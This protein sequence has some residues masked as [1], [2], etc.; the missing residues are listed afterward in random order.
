MS[1][2]GG[3]KCP[4][5]VRRSL[6]VPFLITVSMSGVAFAQEMGPLVLADS[7]FPASTARPLLDPVR[8]G[9]LAPMAV[10]RPAGEAAGDEVAA[11]LAWNATGREPLKNGFSRRLPL[12]LA[13]RLD[14]DLPDAPDVVRAHAG[15]LVTTDGRW[16]AWSG[17]VRVEAA[18][19]LRLHLR[20]GELPAGARLWV[21]GSDGDTVGPFG[22]ELVTD[23]ELWTPSVTGPE[24]RLQVELDR[25]GPGGGGAAFV[26][27]RV[28]ELLPLD[29]ARQALAA[30]ES[31]APQTPVAGTPGPVAA[32]APLVLSCLTDASC[33]T[34]Q[35]LDV[36]APYRKAV[37]FL[38]Y[39]R[40]GDGYV[41]TGGLLNSTA[42]GTPFLLTANHCI[43][44]Q[45]VAST[46]EAFWD[47]TTPTCDGA[48]P[49]L[50][51][52]PRS[53][54]GT[55]LATSKQSD[56]TLLRLL[57]IPD[58]RVFLGW[59]AN[60][61]VVA[62][63]T[64]LYRISHPFPDGVPEPL[65]QRY[66]ETVVS[67][68]DKCPPTDGDG[69]PVGGDGFLKSDPSVGGTFPGSSGA[70]VIIAGGQVVGQLFGSC[71]PN[72]AEGCLATNQEVDGAFSA[73]F[74]DVA[75]FLAATV[76]TSPCASGPA[77]LCL[78]GGRFEV[79]TRWRTPQGGEGDGQRVPLTADTGYFWF[80]NASNVEMV[81]KVLNGCAINSRYWV[82]AGG[83]T[84]VYTEMR[85]RDTASGF[86]KTYENPLNTKFVAI[87]DTDAFATCP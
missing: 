82:F 62:P 41:C 10:L 24:L 40:G 84:N 85:V 47:F 86:S 76:D 74:P 27:D 22:R 29:T 36:I 35:D 81:L 80:F 43:A 46:L 52:L 34:S 8:S 78:D 53:D 71:G 64:R 57:S 9:P 6:L 30:L 7:P 79:K 68:L 21:R 4:S 12:P 19:R 73:T 13:V 56:F 11:L 70:P 18:H 50:A 60:L 63:G 72:P 5:G 45:G 48:P 39:V 55:L 69:R 28:L 3:G 2:L 44:T 83:L 51:S 65:S 26:V 38:E 14:A 32:G 77:T 54:G 20:V 23:G 66:S 15:G 67:A 87:Q 17:A 58:G 33:A 42:S 1:Q 31:R 49:S 61:S 59:N 75:A 37:A 16:L 25:A